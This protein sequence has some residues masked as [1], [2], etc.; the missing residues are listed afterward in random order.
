MAWTFPEIVAA[1][2]AR[3]RV[4]SEQMGQLSRAGTAMTAALWPGAVM[5]NSFTWLGRWLEA[6]PDSLQEWWV[7]TAC[8]GAEMALRFAMS[9]HP[10]LALDALMGQRASSESQL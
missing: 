2:E 3:L 4:S 10:D 5:P 9:W 8:A 6:G 1:A 7:S